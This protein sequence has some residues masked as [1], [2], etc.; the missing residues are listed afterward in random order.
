[1]KRLLVFSFV[2]LWGLALIYDPHA[3]QPE[4]TSFSIAVDWMVKPGGDV[5]NIRFQ[6]QNVKD[7]RIDEKGNLIIETQWGEFTH[8]RPVSYQVV[9]G[10]K[11]AVTVDF[12]VN[13]FHGRSGK[14]A[15]Q[16]GQ[17]KKLHR[18]APSF[19][20]FFVWPLLF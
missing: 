6:Y 13:S 15:V 18:P 7:T 17:S 1:M 4:I 5:D 8:K 19:S 12:N 20:V 3:G 2:V 9:K 16:Q 11:L 14:G 10:K